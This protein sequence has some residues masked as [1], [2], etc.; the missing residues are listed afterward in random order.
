MFGKEKDLM[1]EKMIDVFID[2]YGEDLQDTTIKEV[3]MTWVKWIDAR[4]KV[5]VVPDV[6]YAI[7]D[8]EEGDLISMINADLPN[9]KYQ[10]IKMCNELNEFENTSDNVSSDESDD[11]ILQAQEVADAFLNMDEESFMDFLLN[12]LPQEKEE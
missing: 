11:N 12:H 9:S 2:L 6:C 4:Y 3:L 7:I 5:A 10:A 1:H 8:C